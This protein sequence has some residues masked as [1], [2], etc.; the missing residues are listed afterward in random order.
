MGIVALSVPY[1]KPG[2]FGLSGAAAAAGLVSAMFTWPLAWPAPVP[3]PTSASAV[4]AARAA[5]SRVAWRRA[6]RAGPARPELRQG[7][8]I[9]ILPVQPGRLG[10]LR[11]CH[12][13]PAGRAQEPARAGHF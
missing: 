11:L 3:Q 4:T 10:R 7:R 1:Q 9:G 6:R 13:N 2:A 12:A 8:F 5:P